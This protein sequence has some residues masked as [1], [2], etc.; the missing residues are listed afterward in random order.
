VLSWG[1]FG[2]LVNGQS[3]YDKLART[4][5]SATLRR[6]LRLYLPCFAVVF[7]ECLE[8]YFGVRDIPGKERKSSLLAQIWDF[9]V[10]SEKFASPF[11]IDRGPYDAIHEYEHTVWTI[12]YE[13]SGSLAVFALLLAV[14]R[15][16]RYSKRTIA[17]SI[18][19]GYALIMAQWS[20]CLF[21]SGMLVADYVRQHDGFQGL[22][23]T[24][25][26]SRMG[27]SGMLIIGLWLAG[28]PEKNAK[29]RRPGYEFL[30]SYIPSNWADVEGGERFWWCWAGILIIFSSCHL[31]SVRR[32]FE[33]SFTRYL[34]RISF[35]LYITHRVV[36]GLVGEPVRVG[37]LRTFGEL[38]WSDDAQADLWVAPPL[39]TICIY[40]THWA[41]SLP[42]VLFV[43]HW[44]EILIDGPSTRFARRVDD[45]FTK[46]AL[47]ESH[48]GEELG[49]LP[50]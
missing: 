12:P 42:A 23:K 17:L 30:D 32:I 21:I 10:A 19:A 15:M 13:F 34:G 40:L 28:I 49:R 1:P 9:V 35:M 37:L 18:M 7:W 3:E 31:A 36:L 22:S 41:V 16:R 14:G 29:Y 33:T 44:C 38:Q 4:V 20:Y 46:E 27:W 25:V 48:Q 8:F 45:F 2:A 5:G 47:P 43:A 6:W 24:S 26:P 50:P 39:L 11:K